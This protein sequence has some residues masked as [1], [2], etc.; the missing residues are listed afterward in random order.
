MEKQKKIGFNTILYTFGTLV[1]AALL[2]VVATNFT[3]DGRAFQKPLLSAAAENKTDS[4]E[5]DEYK[6]IK[7][8]KPTETTKKPATK[9]T[10]KPAATSK[11]TKATNTT[12]T[13]RADP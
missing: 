10:D 1:I 2:I 13:T 12:P 8:E 6:T 5:S 11:P 7:Y 9:P 4:T 3:R